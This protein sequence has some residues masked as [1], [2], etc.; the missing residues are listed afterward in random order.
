MT[1]QQMLQEYW[2][3]QQDKSELENREQ[4]ATVQLVQWKSPEIA[5]S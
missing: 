5:M 1:M 2:Q 4:V 3:L